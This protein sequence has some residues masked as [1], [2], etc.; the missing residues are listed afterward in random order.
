MAYF[1]L[2][3]FGRRFGDTSAEAQIWFDRGLVWQY[4]FNHEEAIAC[5]ERVLKLD[6]R[7]VMA[8]WGIAHCLGP[9]Y[10]K[11]WEFFEPD[12]KSAALKRAHDLLAEARD[13]PASEVEQA[14]VAALIARFP[15]DP[16]IEDYGPWNDGFA[17]AMRPVYQRFPDDLDVTAIFVE[18]LMNRTPW[19]L[20]DTLLGQ[21]AKG[22]STVEA[23]TALE[24]AFVQ[25]PAAWGHPG[26]LH[27]YI[28]LMEMS[29]T[30][31]KA[32]PHGDRLVDLVPDSG[33]LVHMASHIDV[34][35]GDY[36]NVV[37]RNR[38]AACVD[39]AYFDY[40]G[41]QNFYTVYRIHNLHFQI[42]GAMFLGRPSDA[43]EG[44]RAL[45]NTLPEPVVRYLPEL[46]EAFVPMRLHV[47]IR[48]GRWSCILKEPFPED[49]ELYSFSTALLHYARTVALANL[50]RHA[51]AEESALL[52][53]RARD[54]V[55]PDRM[56]F[57][58]PCSEVLKVAEA[59]ML[60]ELHYKSGS[61]AVGLDHLRRAVSLDDGLLY[62]EPWGWMQPTRHALGALLMDAGQFEEAE[63]VYRAD[64]GLDETLPRP[65]RH[66]RNVWSLH[67]L[68]E[69]LS[70]RGE[71]VENVH[72]RQLLDQALA[73]AEVT[74]TASCACRSAS[75]CCSDGL[76]RQT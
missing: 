66:P 49:A 17:E 26:L 58:N 15:T 7:H 61:V 63:A 43:F 60:G 16:E 51:E 23:R 5:F 74:I 24:R 20:W 55:Q 59:M 10:N 64:L 25:H 28:H 69:C 52:F 14:L 27:F 4:G 47:L 76:V 44:A 56:M 67:G 54:A 68:Q 48:F 41:G 36:H 29:P 3:S 37:A 70:K 8:R 42:Y 12:E 33:H 39:R 62:D 40:A 9:N 19:A 11:L 71:A 32:L 22:A 34:L 73:R 38:A 2:G 30:P 6:P 50:K 72:V 18:A 35:C 53:A 1:D 75:S 45:V 65:C 57:N 21:P 46:F 13:L 31:E